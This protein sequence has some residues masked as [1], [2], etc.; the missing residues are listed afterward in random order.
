VHPL[1]LDKVDVGDAAVADQVEHLEV[2][3]LDAG[4]LLVAGVDER[5]LRGL[6][7]EFLSLLLLEPGQRLPRV[8]LLGHEL[9]PH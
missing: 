5:E 9:L 7:H 3:E 1:S 2:G 8:H 4:L 6:A